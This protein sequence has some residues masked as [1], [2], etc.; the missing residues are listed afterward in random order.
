MSREEVSMG[1]LRVLDRNGDIE[2]P[3]TATDQ[4]AARQEFDR[5]IRAGWWAYKIEGPQGGEVLRKFDPTAETVV[6]TPR[7]QGG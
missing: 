7:L 2:I 3:W 5:L 4:G 1:K 6:L